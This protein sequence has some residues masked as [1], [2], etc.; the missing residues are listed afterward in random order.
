MVYNSCHATFLFLQLIPFLKYF[1]YSILYITTTGKYLNQRFFS[2]YV[3]KKV[4]N[5]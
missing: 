5:I 1:L 3:G 2:I 4:Y